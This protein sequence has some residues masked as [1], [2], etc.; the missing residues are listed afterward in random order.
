MFF[1]DSFLD[2]SFKV[3][4]AL[5]LNKEYAKKLEKKSKPAAV[6]ATVPLAANVSS[7]C[8]SWKSLLSVSPLTLYSY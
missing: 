5:K 2:R 3:V 1:D 4:R 7:V 6:A 8:M